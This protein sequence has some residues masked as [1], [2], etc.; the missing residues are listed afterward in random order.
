MEK[1]EHIRRDKGGKR[2]SDADVLD[3]QEEQSQ[4]NG[5]SLLFIPG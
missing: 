4:K 5:D 1:I 3:A 2:R